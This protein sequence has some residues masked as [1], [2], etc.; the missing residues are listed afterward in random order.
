MSLRQDLRALADRPLDSSQ[1]GLLVG[2]LVFLFA[3]AAVVWLL[4]G[5]GEAPQGDRP[6]GSAGAPAE[7]VPPPV[8]PSPER[9]L[10]TPPSEEE[11]LE[12][13]EQPSRADVDAARGAARSTLRDYL[14]FSYGGRDAD[15]VG[16][17]SDELRAQLERDT[18]RVPADVREREPELVTVTTEGVT[19]EAAEVLALVDDGEASYSIRVALERD[20]EGWVVTSIDRA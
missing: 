17:V 5:N 16:G 3:V 2:S 15:E 7:P 11:E 12:P 9:D 18:P 4:G 6:A 20:D 13:E 10:A 8:A 1:R 19:A 14:D